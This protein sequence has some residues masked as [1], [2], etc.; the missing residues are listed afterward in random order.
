MDCRFYY[1]ET[2]ISDCKH[3]QT[4]DQM[5]QSD[6]AEFIAFAYIVFFPLRI[7]FKKL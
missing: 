6:D 5:F 2:L 7:R 3:I 1:K 4:D